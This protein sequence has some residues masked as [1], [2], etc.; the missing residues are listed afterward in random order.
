LEVKVNMALEL[1]LFGQFAVRWN[2]QP[3][4]ISSRPA[5]SLFAYLVLHPTIAY[6]REKLAGLIWPETTDENSRRNL[7][8]ALWHI[9]KAF[10]EGVH[11][12]LHS[13][14]L[15]ITFVPTA[16]C[17][18]DVAI[19]EHTKGDVASLDEH[20]AALSTYRGELLPGFYDEWVILEREH[21]QVAYEH[22]MKLLLDRLVE[23]HR[24]NEVLEWG[25]HW[26]S[27]GYTP[28]AAFLALMIAYHG[29]HDVSSARSVY[30]RCVEN[31]RRD[32]GV[33]P[34]ETTR[35]FY[36][37]LLTHKQVLSLP[38]LN[39]L[40]TTDGDAILPHVH[41]TDKSDST[42]SEDL[43]PPIA[44]ATFPALSEEPPYKGLQYFDEA[45]AGL[46]FGREGVVSRWAS[47][48]RPTSGMRNLAPTF[49]HHLLVVVGAS[50]SGKSSLV[51]AGLIPAL[52]CSRPPEY[53]ADPAEAKGCYAIQILTPTDHPLESL[54]A[55][56]NQESTSVLATTS[57]L[58][59]LSQDQRALHLFIRKQ[60]FHGHQGQAETSLLLVV[61]Q[62]EEVF[63][64][65]REEIERRAFIDNLLTAAA[66]GSASVILALR[67]DFYA[68]CIQYTNL[69]QALVLCMEYIEPMNAEEMRQAIEEPAR[70]AGLSFEPGLVDLI[71]RDLGASGGHPA[72]PGALPLLEHA[73]LETWK[74]RQGR[75]LTLA[76]YAE[77]GGVHKAIAKS[78]ESLY[79][80]LP[81][82][83]QRQVRE[84]FL[85]LTVL[86]EESGAK[87][88]IAPVT[89]RRVQIRELAS[90]DGNESLVNSILEILVEA[91]LVT[92]TD[93]IVEVA[94]EALIRE[95]PTLRA[96]L[97]ENQEEHRLQHRLTEATQ[98]WI[99]LERT[100]AELYR[101]ARLAQAQEWAAA[102]MD[103]LNIL[104][105]EFLQASQEQADREAAEQ[106]TLLQRELAAA[107]RAI[108]AA[109]KLAEAEQRR[110]VEHARSNN[111]LRLLTIGLAVFLLASF[112]LAGF[113]LQQRN[114]AIQERRLAVSRELVASAIGN[115][116]IDPE[117]SALL[118]LYALDSEHTSQAED[119]LH[120]AIQTVRVEHI[121]PLQ[122][123]KGQRVL[124]NPQGNLLVTSSNDP[125]KF[126]QTEVWDL[127]TGEKLA[128]LAGGLVARSWPEDNQLATLQPL[129]NQ[130]SRVTF[131]DVNTGKPM[132]SIDID[133]PFNSPIPKDIN[134]EG[135]KLVAAPKD[136]TTIVFDLDTGKRLLSLSSP[137]NLPS[138]GATFSPDGKRFTTSVKNLTGVWDLGSGKEVLSLP[139]SKEGAEAMAFSPDGR[140]IAYGLGETIILADASTGKQLLSLSG[141]TGWVHSLRF[142]PNG[143]LLAASGSNSRVTLW[144]AHTGKQLL[145]LAGHRDT[146]WDVTFSPDGHH[147]ATAS[148]DGSAM[149]WDISAGGGREG[150]S[151]YNSSQILYTNIAF[152]PD[153][154]RLAV[155]GGESGGQVLDSMTGEVVL[156]LPGMTR[157][158][159]GA[160][161]FSPDGNRLAFTNSEAKIH[162]WDLTTQREALVLAGHNDWIGD[163]AFSPDGSRLTSIAYD[164][165]TRMWNMANGQELFKVT[166]DPGQVV[167]KSHIIGVSYSP[168]GSRIAT[169]ADAQPII[170]D[171]NRGEEL[172]ALPEQ[173]EM[174]YSV[175]FSPDGKR[176]A[177][178]L[179]RSMG[180]SIWDVA[181]GE[182]VAQ[183]SLEHRGSIQSI[184]FS[185]DGQQI[186]TGSVDGT[187][188]VF[189]AQTGQE[190]LTLTRQASPITGITLSPDGT[191]LAASNL[192]G[193]VDI[194]YPQL[195]DLL[196]LVKG[197]LVRRLTAQECQTFL[198]I[199]GCPTVLPG[200]G[201]A[202]P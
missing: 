60:L 93:Q 18:T 156:E 177:I 104:E 33:E 19:F 29:L 167:D 122:G 119:A 111:R 124:F 190:S 137:N 75:V 182:R 200:L 192:D 127:G 58:D 28:E 43:Q 67:A 143:A 68:H 63:T 162:I 78:A 46:F 120:Q 44:E 47:R 86:G 10:G 99:E 164:G 144:D 101:G 194:F 147:L 65:C 66:R 146:V 184:V 118:A 160:V 189:D 185:A 62:F 7:R 90:S 89:R 132:R 138:Y 80:R 51:R 188:K 157:G 20:I 16:D 173:P 110:T 174:V 21:L 133:L 79:Q 50:G 136:G 180:G 88:R 97:E 140:R 155:S 95:W 154:K 113:V 85:R 52:R 39:S 59:D 178:G 139:S 151:W 8:Q 3:I 48:L 181:S 76:G 98:N 193:S 123:Q 165:T 14:D 169:V 34:S 69:R 103:R 73:L 6:R 26:I 191:R 187:I 186:Y 202:L 25:E 112:I 87:D 27:L 55:S 1:R 36:A 131:W 32:L 170:W 142:S 57:L 24:W 168:D 163:L 114:L 71:L 17:W 4:E 149:M 56:L 171:A 126:Q 61:D 179:A 107:Q 49:E 91:R 22:K 83:R 31:L 23:A 37:H 106:E 92:I 183:L 148:Q 82:A 5:Q 159:Q 12:F 116:D 109:Q 130:S 74:R 117:R 134:P 102:N 105:R 54:A 161:A 100:P 196:Q 135:T 35:Q 145:T 158:R 153:G 195:K 175:A 121:F 15:S 150:F 70:Q 172:L 141:R 38:V 94:H 197:R 45:D 40:R 166:S 81:P 2:G 41:T 64:M 11:L 96:W 198:H 199:T 129:D 152:S 125:G 201:F 108:E 84:I 72:E 30:Q 77:A 13:D 53:E 115:L 42:V 9:R 128:T 176:L